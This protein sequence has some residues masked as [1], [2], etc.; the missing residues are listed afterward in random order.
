MNE[1]AEEWNEKNGTQSVGGE[2]HT[3]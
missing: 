3:V 2:L 1:K